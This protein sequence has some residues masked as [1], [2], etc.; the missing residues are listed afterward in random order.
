MAY[1]EIWFQG[2]S[3]DERVSRERR[4]TECKDI[5]EILKSIIENDN[6]ST[7][8]Q[9]RQETNYELPNWGLKVADIL[10]SQRALL[11]TLNYLTDR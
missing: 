7:F 4:L 3:A 11:K 8:V 5:L 2:L 10:G 1:P 9:L 6:R